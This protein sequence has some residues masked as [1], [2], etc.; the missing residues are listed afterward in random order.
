MKNETS[1]YICLA[2]ASFTA[3]LFFG[4]MA[5]I[6]TNSVRNHKVTEQAPTGTLVEIYAE[7]NATIITGSMDEVYEWIHE[8]DI[9]HVKGIINI[10]R[11]ELNRLRTLKPLTDVPP[12]VKQRNDTSEFLVKAV[13]INGPVFIPPF[14]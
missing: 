3:A 2:I 13:I 11:D 5:I 9:P 6:E 12:S 7:G 4:Y 14:I 1:K 8:N 10:D